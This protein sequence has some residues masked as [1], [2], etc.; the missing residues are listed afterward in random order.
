[1][2]PVLKMIG[3][4]LWAAAACATIVIASGDATAAYLSPG[5]LGSAGGNAW[6]ATG[7]IA[8]VWCA[9]NRHLP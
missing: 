5:Y 7:A 2:S 1:M 8:G 9:I 6:N 4:G 3:A